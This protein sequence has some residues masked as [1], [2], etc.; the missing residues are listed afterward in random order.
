MRLVGMFRTLM[1]RPRPIDLT[2]PFSAKVILMLQPPPGSDVTCMAPA[3]GHTNGA[4]A[5]EDETTSGID[6]PVDLVST[7]SGPT[8]L[9]T[10]HSPTAPGKPARS[11]AASGY[12]RAEQKSTL[13]QGA[14]PVVQRSA[15]GGRST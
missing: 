1:I 15:A 7:A 3:A 13:A 6:C 11:V 10:R 9:G 12:V 2:V 4:P 8:S 5:F 14:A